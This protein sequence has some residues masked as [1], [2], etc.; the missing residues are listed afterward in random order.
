[1]SDTK[2]VCSKVTLI[3]AQLDWHGAYQAF[4][5]TENINNKSHRY[6]L[7]SLKPDSLLFV[8]GNCH[9]ND[10]GLISEELILFIP[11]AN[12]CYVK[13]CLLYTSRCV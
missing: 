2:Y 8:S 4:A 13:S 3:V 6:F 7:I 9:N 12:H 10:Q 1:M 5:K 11:I